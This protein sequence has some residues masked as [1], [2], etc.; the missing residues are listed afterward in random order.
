[1]RDASV[2]L[3]CAVVDQFDRTVSMR[4]TRAGEMRVV[5][6]QRAEGLRPWLGALNLGSVDAVPGGARSWFYSAAPLP[7][8]VASALRWSTIVAR[9]ERATSALDDGSLPL[10][11]G[12][13]L[14]SPVR[15]LL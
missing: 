5:F 2:G 9:I 4:T 12:S 14:S 13:G 15:S 1:M 3:Y 10:W 8:N 6:K 11:V 7:T